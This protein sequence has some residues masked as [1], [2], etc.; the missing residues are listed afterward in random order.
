ME[1]RPWGGYQIL[2]KEPGIQVKHKIFLRTIQEVFM[3]AGF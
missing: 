3:G 2:H 1:K